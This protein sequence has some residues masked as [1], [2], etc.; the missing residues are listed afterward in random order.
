MGGI[1]SDRC[2]VWEQA[3][4]SEKLPRAE[5]QSLDRSEKECEKCYSQKFKACILRDVHVRP[6][7]DQIKKESNKKY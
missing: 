1:P 6:K 4:T 5:S 2:Q 3:E 7:L